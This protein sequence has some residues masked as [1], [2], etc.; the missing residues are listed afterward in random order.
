M[1]ATEYIGR[2]IVFSGEGRGEMY[3]PAT[4]NVC[5][6][7]LPE[8][9]GRVRL[10]C[11]DA[12]RQARYRIR[13]GHLTRRLQRVRKAIQQRRAVPFRERL[14]DKTSFKPVKELSYGRHVYECMACG[15]PFVVERIG[16]SAPPRR[17]CSEH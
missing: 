13:R 1:R 17:C 7:P 9:K 12:C 2:P 15:E 3:R 11:S 8:G 16:T 6:E 10:T 4:C 5:K 14:F